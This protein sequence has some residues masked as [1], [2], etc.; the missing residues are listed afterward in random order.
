MLRFESDYME[1]CCPEILQR[2]AEIN[3]EKNT[4]YGEDRFCRAAREKIRIA[5]GCEN[6]EVRFLAGG[7]QTNAVVLSALLRSYE[8]VLAAE[9]GHIATHEAGAVEYTGHKVLTLPSHEG[10]VDA[11]DV[12]RFM[13]HLN[14][15]E[16][17]DHL[18]PP[19]AV[20][21]SHPTEYGTLYTRQQLE[22]L[23]KVCDEYQLKLYMDGARLGYG[24]V[25]HGADVTLHDVARLTDVFYIG[26]TK[27]GALFGEAVVVPKP[28]TIP[29]FFT[30]IKQHG[31]LLAKGWVAGIQFDTLFTEGLYTR[32]AHRA[33]HTADILRQGLIE[34]GIPFFIDS[35]TNQLFPILENEKMNALRAHAGFTVWEPLDETHTVIRFVTSWA[36]TEEDVKALLKLL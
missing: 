22:A 20:Y 2:L 26:G 18:V 35:P 5:I 24:L 30:I 10:R 11:E 25:A 19:G 16:A 23:R 14:A 34:K 8:G 13:E 31:A 28:E 6:A 17:R 7:T 15:E 27:V 32:A 33:I 29:H 4:G 21:I 9:T 12:R 1:G 3:L 36:T